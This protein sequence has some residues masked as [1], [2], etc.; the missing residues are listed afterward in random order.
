M[1][2]RD[3]RIRGEAVAVDLPSGQTLFATL[4]GENTGGN[5][6]EIAVQS[7]MPASRTSSRSN[8]EKAAGLLE[9]GRQA[10]VPRDSY[11][12]LVRFRDAR[13]PSTIEGVDPDDLSAVFGP[14]VRLRSI[15][16]RTTRSEPA[17]LLQ[18]RLPWLGTE[19]RAAARASNGV[20]YGMNSLAFQRR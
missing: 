1:T 13:D 7:L 11:P 8:E 18:G 9:A 16:I 3:V 10:A 19:F 4:I 2:G 15:T 17:F 12:L 14:G 20:E 5:A 6:G